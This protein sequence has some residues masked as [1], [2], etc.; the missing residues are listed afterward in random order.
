MIPLVAILV[1]LGETSPESYAARVCEPAFD[2]RQI[3]TAWPATTDHAAT[4][5]RDAIRMR[6]PP[7]S[8]L[9]AVETPIAALLDELILP[10]V[11]IRLKLQTLAHGS[12]LLAR[13]SLDDLDHMVNKRFDAPGDMLAT[14]CGAHWHRLW[15]ALPKQLLASRQKWTG[16]V[17]EAAEALAVA[18][19][20]G[21]RALAIPVSEAIQHGFSTPDWTS[22][23]GNR[24]SGVCEKVTRLNAAYHIS[25]LRCSRSTMGSSGSRKREPRLPHGSADGLICPMFATD[26][27]MIGLVKMFAAVTRISDVCVVQDWIPPTA[28]RGSWHVIA[29][30][31]RI[32]RCQCPI[33]YVAAFRRNRLRQIRAAARRGDARAVFANAAAVCTQR[34]ER[35][36]IH[37]RAGPGRLVRPVLVAGPAPAILESLT[38]LLCDGAIEYLDAGAIDDA[39]IWVSESHEAFDRSSAEAAAGGYMKPSHIELHKA[40][41]MGITTDSVP[42][43]HHN[44]STRNNFY[45]SSQSK[46]PFG[47]PHPGRGQAP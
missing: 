29:D 37:I 35:A 9:G 41:H 16:P 30:G 2:A 4:M 39:T 33:E 40:L 38:Q 27:E 44:Q 42:F 19:L 7:A 32:G 10:H 43:P 12:A 18:G 15:A 22:S 1:L 20:D 46:Q 21:I 14:A 24:I 17:A 47:V 23:D 13:A 36:E 31:V 34:T 3:A 8:A 11:P 25:L 6:F 28:D 26:D 5:F 45:A